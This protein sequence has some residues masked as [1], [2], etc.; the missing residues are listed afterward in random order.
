MK[1]ARL[2][3]CC[4]LPLA[5]ITLIAATS[6]A[7]TIVPATPVGGTSAVQAA[8]LTLSADATIASINVLTQGVPN[9]DFQ[10]ASGGTC[11]VGKTYTSGQTCTVKY[12][13]KPTHPGSRYGAVVLYANPTPATAIATTYLY[14]TGTGPQVVFSPPMGSEIGANFHDACAISID[15]KGNLFVA[16]DGQLY[17]VPVASGYT[18]STLVLSI[19]AGGIAIDGAGNLFVTDYNNNAIKEFVAASDYATIITLGHGFSKPIGV[20]VD[21]AGNVFVADSGNYAVKE[22]IA[23]GGYTTVRVL[24]S[25]G[26]ADTAPYIAPYGVAVDGSENLFISSYGIYNPRTSGSVFE[27]FAA[28]GYTTEQIFGPRVTSEPEGLAVDENANVFVAEWGDN[29]IREVLAN[30]GYKTILTVASFERYPCGVAVGAKGNVFFSGPSQ[31]YNHPHAIW[32]LDFSDPPSLKFADTTVGSTSTDSPMTITVTNDGNEALQFS[33]LSYPADFPETS[34]VATDCTSSTTLAGGGSCTL[35]IDF[36]PPPSSASG[37]STPLS[38]EISFT[39]NNLN[40]SDTAQQVAT[41]GNAIFV[42]PALTSPVNSINGSTAT[43]AWTPGSATTFKL[44]L[45]TALGSNNIYGSGPTNSTSK[46]VSG[47]PNKTIY[48]RLNYM[49]NGAWEY[50]DYSFAA[51]PQLTTP[52]PG[53]TLSGPNI[54]FSW[55]PGG[56]TN[57]QFRLGTTLGGNDLDDSGT[58]TSTSQTVYALPTNGKTLYARLYYQVNSVWQYNDYTYTASPAPSLTSPTPGSTLTGST[59]TFTW[60]PAGST[61]FQFR[62][63]TTLGSNNIYGSGQTTKT[64]VTVSN[65]PTNGETIHAVLYYMVNGAWQ[66]VAYT[67]TAQ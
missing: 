32:K 10:S 67:Y 1:S 20:A 62:L 52:P 47:L 11:T 28:S 60:N 45:G 53:S 61:T 14:G 16:A 19:E 13:F 49:L 12:T 6:A 43:F 17:E 30:D 8:T 18:E 25:T 31:T 38:G 36:S 15:G 33:D 23:E 24:F 46:T 26:S 21:R 2:F 65:L 35:S 3:P 39:D 9:Q 54:T 37:L 5:A 27:L 51:V 44:Q 59:V 40:V 29:T 55:T 41:A 34:G 4:I 57:F 50:L 66:N 22:I 42:P 63:G 64:S 7:Q 48:A 56:S 58:I